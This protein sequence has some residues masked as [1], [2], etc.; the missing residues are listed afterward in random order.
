MKKR[1]KKLSSISI[2]FLFL[3]IGVCSVLNVSAQQISISGNVVDESGISVI[4]ASVLESK[5][6]ANPVFPPLKVL[7]S[8]A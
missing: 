5:H 2:R 3:I 8:F 1:K 6:S 4:G 7:L